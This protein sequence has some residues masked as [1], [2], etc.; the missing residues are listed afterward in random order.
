M[1]PGDQ[2]TCPRCGTV[3]T[4]YSTGHPAHWQPGHALL[5]SWHGTHHEAVTGGPPTV[6]LPC[7]T[8]QALRPPAT[9]R[10]SILADLYLNGCR[11]SGFE[12]NTDDAV[13]AVYQRWIAQGRVRCELLQVNPPPVVAPRPAPAPRPPARQLGLFG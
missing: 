11:T 10:A 8:G 13:E 3:A 12:W 9:R 6:C 5:V 4:A 1:K 7:A 2:V